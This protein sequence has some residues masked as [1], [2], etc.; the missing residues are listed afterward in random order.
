M[1]TMTEKCAWC[2]DT[3]VTASVVWGHTK[4]P[5]CDGCAETH[6]EV[7]AAQ[8]KEAVRDAVWNG[9]VDSTPDVFSAFLNI[10]AAGPAMFSRLSE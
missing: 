2:G 6:R 9:G 5:L 1:A 8:V 10:H 3:H 4:I 7:K